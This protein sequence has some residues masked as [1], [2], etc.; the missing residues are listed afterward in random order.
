SS[1]QDRVIAVTDSF[2]KMDHFYW[3]LQAWLLYRFHALSAC[4]TLLLTLLALYTD[5]SPGLTAFVLIAAS[6][7]VESTHGLCKQYGQLQMDFVS[8][9]RVV[10]LLHLD[11]ESPGT[12]DPPASW[13]TYTGDIVFDNVTMRYAPHL[14]P[15]LSGISCRI[16]GGSTTAL[17]GRT[18]SGKSTL[19][20]ALLATILP[21]SGT[22]TLDNVDIF[23]VNKQALRN[24]VTFL[25]QDP[26]LFSG[27]MRQNLDPLNEYTDYACD[28]VVHRICGTYQWTLETQVEAGGRNLSQGQRQLVGLARAVLR[29]SAIVILDEATASID[30]KTAMYIQQVLREEM[31][32]STVITI[33]HRL[34]AVKDA[35][36]LIRLDKGRVVEQGPAP[37]ELPMGAASAFETDHGAE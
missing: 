31:R 33:A 10:E 4:S 24:R 14:N 28:A 21:S 36:Y 13:P 23:T 32:E 19:A 22:I 7:F 18:G 17:L 16:P 20:L 37:G 3:S 34:E 26:I 11:Q 35:D 29:R 12:I 15:S 5:V 6:Q 8:V 27:S 9:E 30:M 25:A 2:Q 1:F